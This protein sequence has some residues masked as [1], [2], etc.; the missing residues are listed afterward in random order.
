MDLAWEQEVNS[1]PV[2]G[3]G[4]VR[5]RLVSI[6][7]SVSMIRMNAFLKLEQE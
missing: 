7:P 5:E 3:G 2:G 4:G 1:E 6:S